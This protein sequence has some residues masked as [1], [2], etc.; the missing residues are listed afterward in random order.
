MLPNTP[1]GLFLRVKD[2]ET[3]IPLHEQGSAAWLPHGNREPPPPSGGGFSETSRSLSYLP[4]FRRNYLAAARILAGVNEAHLRRLQSGRGGQGVLPSDLSDVQGAHHVARGLEATRSTLVLSTALLPTPA[5]G[6][7]LRAVWLG[8]HDGPLALVVQHV[9]ELACASLRHLLRLDSTDPLRR[10]VER[11][12]NHEACAREGVDDLPGRL[13]AGIPD[14]SMR[15]V[16][17]RV[18]ATLQPLVAPRPARLLRLSLG[19]GGE[20]LVAVLHRRLHSAAR[21]GDSRLPIRRTRQGVHTEVY[22]HH[23]VPFKRLLFLKFAHKK[24]TTV[25]HS[26]FHE[27]TWK[28]NSFGDFHRQRPCLAVRQQQVSVSDTGTLVRVG[29]VAVTFLAPWVLGF[30]MAFLP[31]RRNG[32]HGLEKLLDDLLDGLGVEVGVA[33]L[34]PDFPATFCWPRPVEATDAVVAH[35]QIIPEASGFDASRREGGP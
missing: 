5:Y 24:N 3:K 15:F 31:K 28:T 7:R 35:D 16:E 29:H 26:G 25:F 33:V 22:A 23:G 14:L 4:G 10:S 17:H 34:G 8:H 2:Q 20:A 18:L 13:V 1:T 19:Q 30:G 9:D 27:T 12:A 21:H 6:T 11:L 32:T